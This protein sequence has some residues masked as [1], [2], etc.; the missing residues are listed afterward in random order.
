MLVTLK[1]NRHIQ[2]MSER[3]KNVF[4]RGVIP[5]VSFSIHPLRNLVVIQFFRQITARILN[6]AIGM[7]DQVFTRL[8]CRRCQL[9]F[10]GDHAPYKF[11]P[12][13][14]LSDAVQPV[15]KLTTPLQI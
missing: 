7:E 10:L 15:K 2:F 5:A 1:V 6:P 11:L 9:L 14:S 4:R 8:S 3:F 13:E 12:R